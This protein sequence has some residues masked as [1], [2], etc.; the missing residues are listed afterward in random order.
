MVRGRGLFGAVAIASGAL[1]CLLLSSRPVY[2]AD[3]QIL[4]ATTTSGSYALASSELHLRQSDA[5]SIDVVAPRPQT[6]AKVATNVFGIAVPVW[7]TTFKASRSFQSGTV[8]LADYSGYARVAAVS[9]GT[10]SCSQS[11]TLTIDDRNALLTVAGGAGAIL[12]A[13]SLLLL[14]R[15]ARRRP[16]ALRRF[17]GM[18]PGV[19]FGLGTGLVAQQSSLMDPRNIVG[20]AIPAA[21]LLLGALVPGSLYRSLPLTPAPARIPEP[22]AVGAGV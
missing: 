9:F 14:A 12:G 15:L 19:L 16:T 20:L 22:E 2:A 18:A 4:V 11:V 13:I 6:Y 8:N 17:W 21:T 1:L 7:R 10:N 3:C 5:V